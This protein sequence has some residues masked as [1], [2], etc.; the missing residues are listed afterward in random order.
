LS[1]RGTKNYND[2]NQEMQRLDTTYRAAMQL[3]VMDVGIIECHCAHN[4]EEG[5][6]VSV[7]A[8]VFAIRLD[9]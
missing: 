3:N 1:N 2:S 8:N 7:Q 5:D 4:E 6:M 9:N